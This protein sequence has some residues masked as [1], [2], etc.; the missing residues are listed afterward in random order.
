MLFV[1]IQNLYIWSN[2]Q[3]QSHFC[4][5]NVVYFSF[6]WILILVK[7]K[8]MNFILEIYSVDLMLTSY[9]LSVYSTV[10]Y[11]SNEYFCLLP[12]KVF[13]SFLSLSLL[14]CINVSL[15]NK[16][17]IFL[18]S[19]YLECLHWKFVSARTDCTSRGCKL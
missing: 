14:S 5:C 6:L 19:M 3:F 16:C 18:V 11:W 10:Q 4:N 9:T 1:A 17:I 13:S 2:S 7:S 12:C 15:R 8:F